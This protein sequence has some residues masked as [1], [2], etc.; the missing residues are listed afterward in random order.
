MEDGHCPRRTKRNLKCVATMSASG[1]VT[2]NV[3]VALELEQRTDVELDLQQSQ[4]G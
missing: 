1:E 2:E 4:T 3:E